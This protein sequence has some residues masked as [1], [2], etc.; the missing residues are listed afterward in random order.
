MNQ[1]KQQHVTLEPASSVSN[2]GDSS[3]KFHQSATRYAK[4][5]HTDSTNIS[6]NM[7]T[8]VTCTE[9]SDSGGGCV[10]QNNVC[11]QSNKTS[12]LAACFQEHMNR[13]K[14]GFKTAATTTNNNKLNVM[15][16]MPGMAAA[17][18]DRSELYYVAQGGSSCFELRKRSNSFTQGQTTVNFL[19]TLDNEHSHIHHHHQLLYQTPFIFNKE[20]AQRTLNN[21]NFSDEQ[22][23]QQASNLDEQA[24]ND[25]NGGDQ[26]NNQQKFQKSSKVNKVN[27]NLS[28]QSDDEE[29]AIIKELNNNLRQSADDEMTAE[30]ASQC[31]VELAMQVASGEQDEESQI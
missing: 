27:F 6:Y 16:L 5:S 23:Q 20:I 26:L 15:M 14:G 25:Q 28:N 24:I 12:G 11:V 18:I 13:S 21:N 8:T 4:N 10:Y 30:L 2:T 7:P 17:A 1:L 29:E 3:G 31:S 19:S 9:T 22:R